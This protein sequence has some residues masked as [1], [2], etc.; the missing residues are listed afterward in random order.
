MIYEL[1]LSS[2]WKSNAF[3]L[4]RREVS[5]LATT[6]NLCF[7][8]L[9]LDGHSTRLRGAFQVVE[10]ISIGH[11]HKNKHRKHKRIQ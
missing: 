8:L 10:K 4:A 9:S 2:L 7:V 11:I 1:T 6:K 5:Q 3:G